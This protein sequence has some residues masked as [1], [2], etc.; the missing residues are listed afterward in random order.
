[1]GKTDRT[2]IKLPNYQ[3][4]LWMLWRTRPQS[5]DLRDHKKNAMRACTT[6]EGDWS[7]GVA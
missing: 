2:T 7:D 4:D 1:M 6:S 5:E 3:Y